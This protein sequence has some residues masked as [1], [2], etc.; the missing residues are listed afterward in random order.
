[1]WLFDEIN[2]H[3][4]YSVTVKNWSMLLCV[5]ESIWTQKSDG[6]KVALALHTDLPQEVSHPSVISILL[7]LTVNKFCSFISAA[8]MNCE[9]K[10]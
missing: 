7:Y 1:M 9:I 8:E 2:P 10:Y 4:F 6:G 3:L 5:G